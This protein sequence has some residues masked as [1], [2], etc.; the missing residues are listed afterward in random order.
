M[1]PAD[2]RAHESVQYFESLASSAYRQEWTAPDQ[3]LVINN[4]RTLHARAAVAEDDADRQL[5]RI[6]YR[7]PRR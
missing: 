5:T 4:R 6:A 3:V 7:V 2:E 1:T